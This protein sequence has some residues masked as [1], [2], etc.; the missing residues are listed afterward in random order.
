MSDYKHFIKEKETMKKSFALVLALVMALSLTTV[1]WGASVDCSAGCSDPTNHVAAVGNNHY[2]DLQE[3]IKDAAPSGTVE[4]LKD[5]T[6]D[7]WVQFDQTLT[8]GD[9]TLITLNMDGLT[10]NGNGHK[11]TVNNV[12]S[13]ETTKFMFNGAKE[14]NINNLTIKIVPSDRSAISLTSGTIEKVVFEG[15]QCGVCPGTGN[16]TI[17]ECEFKTTSHAIYHEVA[18]DNLTV[19]NNEFNLGANANIIILRG[20]ETFTGNKV[21][22]GRT[23]NIASG[24][25]PVVTGN[26]FNTRVKTYVSDSAISG[27]SFGTNGKIELATGVT[28][29][30][31]SGNYWGGSAP[32]DAQLGGATATTYA[33]TVA[34]DGTV[35]DLY[36]SSTN[37]PVNPPAPPAPVYPY[38]PPVVEDTTD[39]DVTSAQTFDAGIALYVGV[40]VL[41][42]MGTVALSKKRED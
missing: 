24:A 12:V 18:R 27:N 15:G 5:V 42:A 28:G 17:N 38:Y 37:T 11:L 32:T 10:I 7:N 9:G 6:V 2:T 31:V 16:V 34:N 41:G 13:P 14:L 19:T 29:V 4:I 1:A 36:Y 39:K 20:S 33:T 23:V 30:D 40:S 8:I 21:N 35:G 3:A 25:S 26:T 22:S